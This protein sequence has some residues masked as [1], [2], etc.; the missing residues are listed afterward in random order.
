M[1]SSDIDKGKMMRLLGF[2][3]LGIAY[4]N[5]SMNE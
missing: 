4:N 5:T 1:E 3:E 2:W